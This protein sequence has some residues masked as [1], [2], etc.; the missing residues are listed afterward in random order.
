[1]IIRKDYIK[2]SEVKKRGQQVYLKGLNF[3]VW[4]SWVWLKRNGKRI[5]RFVISTKPMK[6]K[7]IT[8]WGKRRWQIEGFF[9]TSKHQ[10]S[11]H[12]FGQKTL[13]GVYRWLILSLISFLLAYWVYLYLGY[14]DSLDWSDNAKFALI[15]LFPHLLLLSLLKQLELLIPW[16]HE[17]GFELC[18]MRC[19]I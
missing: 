15:L 9:K 12:R 3:P 7:T 13:L 19:K 11:L 17:R 8:R 2:V 10:F 16:L 4:L 1:M 18:L 5:Q 6:G 14:Q